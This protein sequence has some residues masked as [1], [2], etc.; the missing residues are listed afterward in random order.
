MDD[1]CEGGVLADDQGDDDR[2]C[3]SR[4]REQAPAAAREPVHQLA[5]EDPE[6]GRDQPE[7]VV[8]HDHHPGPGGRSQRCGQGR[9]GDGAAERLPIVL[10]SDGGA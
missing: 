4:C 3:R 6:A 1:V 9:G 2:N 5:G 10:V 7:R 8:G